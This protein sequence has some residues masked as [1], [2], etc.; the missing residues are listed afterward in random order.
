MSNLLLFWLFIFIIDVLILSLIFSIKKNYE[1]K[2]FKLLFLY[3]IFLIIKD[4]YFFIFNIYSLSL[5]L[6]FIQVIFYLLLIRK[7]S[8]LKNIDVFFILLNILV[9]VFYYINFYFVLLQKQYI[10][11]I[12]ILIILDIIYLLLQAVLLKKYDEPEICILVKIKY[13][14]FPAVLFIQFIIIYYY[15]QDYRAL[16]YFFITYQNILLFIFIILINNNVNEKQ[17]KKIELLNTEHNSLL[18][19]IT[20][21]G[22]N[23]REK[24]DYE[25]IYDLILKTLCEKIKAESGSFLLVDDHE[26]VLRVKSVYGTAIPLYKIPND[27]IMSSINIKD[28]YIN[29]PIKLGKTLVGKVV[30]K[31]DPVFIENIEKFIKDN[32]YLKEWFINSLIITPVIY[33][34]RLFGVF[35]IVKRFNNNYFKKTDFEYSKLYSNYI[36]V[37]LNN[38]ITY[39]ILSHKFDI[40]KEIEIASSIQDKLMPNNILEIK[41]LSISYFNLPVRG[42]SGDYFDIIKYD[43][44]KIGIL[45]CDVAGR[46]I[47]A[48]LVKLMI[49]SIF[50]F[51]INQTY[52]PSMVVSSI[53]KGITNIINIDNFATLGYLIYDKN[54]KQLSYSNAAHMPLLIY[55]NKEND[56]F[57]I[58]TNGLPIGID[59]KASYSL[60]NL[61]INTDD[62][63]IFYTDGIIEAMNTNGDQFCIEY[64]K[65][66]IKKNNHE[67][68][69]IIMSKIKNYFFKFMENSN[70]LDD[71]TMLLIKVN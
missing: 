67:P 1:I 9:I 25:K 49:R 12:N 35:V 37:T 21:I 23:I 70:Q 63:L 34:K 18:N 11:F 4:F 42:I 54:T 30:K 7:F 15:K 44:E 51:V 62:I 43:N 52:D 36:A 20:N 71:Y 65:K 27:I 32:N 28:Y 10:D 69:E 39:Y 2:T 17:Q 22:L 50:Y 64:I 41:G 31:G 8:K 59:K 24:T 16:N 38:I 66:I 68:C 29:T 53:N 47:N 19:L 48:T 3:I 26:D 13:Y 45:V 14:L 5:I 6:E 40:D 58:D 57:N 61:S 55:K 46:G 33:N 56:F 60:K